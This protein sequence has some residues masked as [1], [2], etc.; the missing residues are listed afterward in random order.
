MFFTKNGSTNILLPSDHDFPANIF[1]GIEMRNQR[2]ITAALTIRVCKIGLEE[3]RWLSASRALKRD[4]GSF[5]RRVILVSLS[6]YRPLLRHW[7]PGS[8]LKEMPELDCRE[9]KPSSVPRRFERIRSRTRTGYVGVED[10]VATCVY[11]HMDDPSSSVPS[12]SS[13]AQTP[14]LE[15]RFH[16]HHASSA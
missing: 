13:Q 11:R 16:T 1:L 4:S 15:I 7:I 2:I 10:A 5:A 3:H 9:R 14:K 8:Y 12:S 6:S